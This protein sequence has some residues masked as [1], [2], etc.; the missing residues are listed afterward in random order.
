MIEINAA[1]VQEAFLSI[2]QKRARL[3]G[4]VSSAWLLKQNNTGAEV[5]VTVGSFSH[6]GTH[7]QFH[8]EDEF[9]TKSKFNKVEIRE[10]ASRSKPHINT[11][12]FPESHQHSNDCFVAHNTIHTASYDRITELGHAIESDESR[13]ERCRA[14]VTKIDR[15]IGEKSRMPNAEILFQVFKFR[16][17]EF[18]YDFYVGLRVT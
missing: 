12:R 16:I 4:Y 7:K 14:P 3:R 13:F 11:L 10:I 1:P 2:S 18:Q 6:N 15:H 9:E 8:M 5:L 17:L